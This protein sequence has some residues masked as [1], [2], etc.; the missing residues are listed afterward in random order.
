M[1]KALTICFSTLACLILTVPTFA[2][3]ESSLL[4]SATKV[5]NV[6][7][8]VFKENSQRTVQDGTWT[9]K[10]LKFSSDIK[11]SDSIKNPY[12]LTLMIDV[13]LTMKYAD[14]KK[15]SGTLQEEYGFLYLFDKQS[16]TWILDRA[17]DDGQ[18]YLHMFRS[19]LEKVRSIPMR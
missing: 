11:K 14:P 12:H 1:A 16:N 3:D 17:N 6:W 19:A 5:E 4:K 18:L 7:K 8:S 9:Y 13:N 15:T 2:A 10:P